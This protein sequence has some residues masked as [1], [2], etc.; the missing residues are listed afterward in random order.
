ML[1]H[2]ALL[3]D[4][5][6]SPICGPCRILSE[7]FLYC[8]F[9]CGHL[10]EDLVY[11]LHCTVGVH[12]LKFFQS[13]LCCPL[14]FLHFCVF[15]VDD[16]MPVFISS[17]NVQLMVLLIDSTKMQE[18]CIFLSQL[19]KEGSLGSQISSNQYK[20]GCKCHQFISSLML[21]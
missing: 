2:Y 17:R 11:I 19:F 3:I 20:Y 21:M 10:R 7:I 15:L 18:Q 4:Q 14:L 1:L 5:V 8:V 12:E 6:K 16:F 13:V 9:V